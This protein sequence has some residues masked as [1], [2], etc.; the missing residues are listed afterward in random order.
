MPTD[1]CQV[2]HKQKW[3][4]SRADGSSN[5]AGQSHDYS[6]SKYSGRRGGRLLLGS[7]ATTERT[8]SVRI[9]AF[10]HTDAEPIDEFAAQPSG[11]DR[12]PSRS[13]R[14]YV[15]GGAWVDRRIM[16]QQPANEEQDQYEHVA[17]RVV[18]QPTSRGFLQESRTSPTRTATRQVRR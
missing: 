18:I 5:R 14:A 16:P 7:G 12:K 6:I 15:S 4:S 17:A 3:S 8:G 1:F 11:H 2:R 10:V 13:K 9:G